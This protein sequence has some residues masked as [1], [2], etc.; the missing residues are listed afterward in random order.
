M[1]TPAYT[2]RTGTRYVEVTCSCCLGKGTL[3]W[4]AQRRI[5]L[6]SNHNDLPI[7]CP[8]CSGRKRVWVSGG[9]A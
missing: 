9:G 1:T 3:D 4:P 5:G 6:S 7:V 8:R 2:S